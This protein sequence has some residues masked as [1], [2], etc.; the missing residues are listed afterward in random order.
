MKP[1][2]CQPGLSCLSERNLPG[3][4]AEGR[5]SGT[6]KGGGEGTVQPISP[7]TRQDVLRPEGSSRFPE[8]A[9]PSAHQ[10]SAASGQVSWAL[11][12]LTI[13]LCPGG[14]LISHKPA[15]SPLASPPLSLTP[16]TPMER[17]SLHLGTPSTQ[18][19]TA[20]TAEANGLP[21]PSLAPSAERKREQRGHNELIFLSPCPH[22]RQFQVLPTVGT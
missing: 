13:A 11:L 17:K 12:S 22:R 21:C 5:L 3:L 19:H 2:C 18:A 6:T 16:R 10:G 8:G 4:P 15:Q 9:L 1:S 14:R 20:A 7:D